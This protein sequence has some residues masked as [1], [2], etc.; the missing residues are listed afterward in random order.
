MDRMKKTLKDQSGFTLIE[1]LIVVAIIAILIAISI[2]VVNSALE[3]AR[4]ATDQANLRA[5]KAAAIVMYLDNKT[6][7]PITAAGGTACYKASDGSLQAATA[8]NQEKYGQSSALTGNEV[9]SVTTTPKGNH[10]H[11]T[12]DGDGTVTALNWIAGHNATP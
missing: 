8:A 6:G 1:M 4:K 11:I 7:E 10:I 9:G 3:K 2:P 12:L 5:A